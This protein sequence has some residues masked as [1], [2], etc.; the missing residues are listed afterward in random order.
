MPKRTEC[1]TNFLVRGAIAATMLFSVTEPVFA[2]P[3]D[4]V[5]F[6]CIPGG[7]PSGPECTA[8]KAVFI[9][10]ATPLPVLP[11]FQPWNCPLSSN[12]AIAQ[13]Y[14]AAPE[15]DFVRAIRVWEVTYSHRERGKDEECGE[16]GQVTLGQ[17]ND[18]G[19]YERSSQ[20]LSAIPYWIV[21]DRSCQPR[22]TRGTRAVGL[23][24]QD[25]DGQVGREVIHY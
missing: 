6:L 5:M 18:L 11:P 22:S 21:P 10:R 17:Y 9:Q 20:P 15:F 25:N 12:A 16:Q 3:V 14:L 4:C 8:A 23:E 24:W 13:S 2:A 7:W 1:L 19:D